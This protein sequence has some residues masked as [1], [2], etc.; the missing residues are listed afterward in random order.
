MHCLVVLLVLLLR[1]LY[2]REKKIVI[3]NLFQSLE[4]S[5]V[6]TISC[7]QCAD[8]GDP[9]N[10]NSPNVT[11]SPST[12]YYCYVRQVASSYLQFSFDFYVLETNSIDGLCPSELC[13]QRMR[14]NLCGI[15]R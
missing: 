12:C 8:C 2:Q 3:L 14:S 7:F 13:H 6:R 11:R 4:I 5:S 9:F 1:K 15:K 10:S